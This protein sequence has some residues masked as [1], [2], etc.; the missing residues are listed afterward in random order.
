MDEITKED[1]TGFHFCQPTTGIGGSHGR[2]REE[3]RDWKKT[4]RTIHTKTWRTDQ[5]RNVRTAKNIQMHKTFYTLSL[6]KRQ[7]T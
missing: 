6:Y 1:L 2:R 3:S 4:A 5:T 7:S